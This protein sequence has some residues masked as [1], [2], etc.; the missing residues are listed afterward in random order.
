V[1]CLILRSGALGDIILTFPLVKACQEQY[2]PDNIFLAAPEALRSIAGLCAIDH[3]TDIDS[4]GWHRLYDPTPPAPA[5]LP[6]LLHTTNTVF[7]LLGPAAGPVHL[8]LT[9]LGKTVYSLAPPHGQLTQHV[10]EYLGTVRPVPGPL[11]PAF[12]NPALLPDLKP[13]LQSVLTGRPPLI[14]H[15]GTGSP[16]KRI[17]PVLW[18]QFIASHSS[19]YPIVLLTGPAEEDMLDFCNGLTNQYHCRHF[20]GL[21]LTQAAALIQQSKAWCGLDAGMSHLAALANISCYVIFHATNPD[22]WRPMGEQ[23]TVIRP[24]D[25]ANLE[26]A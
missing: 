20:H 4:G 1:N 17:D 6:E 18:E 7:N 24:E 26:I 13:E 16:A 25:L 23:V 21:S 9:A 3:F 8:N 22:L 19:E 11:E 15:P 2:G 10:S 14:I 12:I 5:G